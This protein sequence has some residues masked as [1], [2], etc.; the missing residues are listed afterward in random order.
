MCFE[1][2]S[3]L[4]DRNVSKGNEEIHSKAI[5]NMILTLLCL[6]R[7][8]VGPAKYSVMYKYVDTGTL[9]WKRHVSGLLQRYK[10]HM[11]VTRQVYKISYN[12]DLFWTYFEC[13]G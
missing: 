9:G 13:L 6:A 7:G 5:K 2:S 12:H 8:Y 1:P 10:P 11:P 4:I 3:Q